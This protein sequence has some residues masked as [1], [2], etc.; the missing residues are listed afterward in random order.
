MKKIVVWDASLFFLELS[1]FVALLAMLTVGENSLLA[2][3][4]V[5]EN[6][7]IKSLSYRLLGSSIIFI[8]YLL[9]RLKEQI[10]YIL[11]KDNKIIIQSRKLFRK[12]IFEFKVNDIQKCTMY[13]HRGSSNGN[14][15][16][17]N[18][19]LNNNEIFNI[20][21]NGVTPVLI[22][23]I[24]KIS[25]F[26]DKFHYV[27]CHTYSPIAAI[28]EQS[29]QIYEKIINNDKKVILQ[30]RIFSLIISIAL[31]SMMIFIAYCISTT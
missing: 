23:K 15:I 28:E 7:L 17:L 18:I 16:R 9:T 11:L 3:L 8:C 29:E 31:S 2:M 25:N 21:H 1:T 6:S 12:R 27:I 13:I 19:V 4:T 30:Q 22:E 26:V 10:N 20:Q 14:N 5:G 24:S